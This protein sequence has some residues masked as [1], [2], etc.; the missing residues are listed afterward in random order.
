[1][2]KYG[3]KIYAV[4]FDKTLSMARYPEVGEPNKD[5]FEF[6]ISE[7]MKGAKI[8]LNSC[9]TK[10]PLLKAVEFCNA[11]GLIFDAINDNVDTMIESYGDNPRKISADFY[12]DDK[13]IRP[14]LNEKMLGHINAIDSLSDQISAILDLLMLCDESVYIKSIHTSAEMCLQ[15][16]DEIMK[17]VYSIKRENGL[18][19][20]NV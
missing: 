19:T 6:L 2:D 7:Q 16:H 5:L 18:D 3:N 12:I 9:R 4:D 11:N 8:I 13:A 1:M 14:N 20:R 15:I 10:E 17:E